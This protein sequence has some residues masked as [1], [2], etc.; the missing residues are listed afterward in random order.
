MFPLQ[1]TVKAQSHNEAASTLFN[2]IFTH[3]HISLGGLGLS[4]VELCFS[5]VFIVARVCFVLFV[6]D[7]V[8]L[9]LSSPL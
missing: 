9:L 4:S 7:Q 2:F 8:F 6:P 5:F 1:R 3:L